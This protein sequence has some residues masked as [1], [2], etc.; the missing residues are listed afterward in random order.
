MND[1]DGKQAFLEAL[2]QIILEQV[3]NF[4]RVKRVQVKDVANGHDY[5][6]QTDNHSFLSKYAE[7]DETNLLHMNRIEKELFAARSVCE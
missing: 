5:G 6:L 7:F 1:T 3:R 2:G 4:L